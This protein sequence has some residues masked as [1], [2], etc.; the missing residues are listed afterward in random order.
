MCTV[1]VLE[2][3][4]GRVVLLVRSL[5]GVC[6]CFERARGCSLCRVLVAD[7]STH[8]QILLG[9][10]V[11]SRYESDSHILEGTISP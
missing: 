4:T 10:V 11:F 7:P 6:Q 5:D 8:I 9:I 3:A 2:D 1:R